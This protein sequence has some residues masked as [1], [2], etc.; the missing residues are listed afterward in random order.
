ML[1]RAFKCCKLRISPTHRGLSSIYF[2]PECRRPWAR[3][4]WTN[5]WNWLPFTN[6]ALIMSWTK[7]CF[8]NHGEPLVEIHWCF[9]GGLWRYFYHLKPSSWQ[10][11]GEVY[12]S[13]H[14][15]WG[16]RNRAF[17]KADLTCGWALFHM[18]LIRD[19]RE[20][21]Y[22]TVTPFLLGCEIEQRRLCGDLCSA[23]YVRWP[24]W[25][26]LPAWCSSWLTR[27]R[28][29]AYYSG[30]PWGSEWRMRC[31]PCWGIVSVNLQ[32]F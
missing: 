12:F 1:P 23:V 25:A 11:Q 9:D 26:L 2:G 29:A 31:F 8:L 20:S 21:R 6:L 16:R 17:L 15:T 3:Q 24:A 7:K 4:N 14:A 32:I 22:S 30:R 18:F 10:A 13:Q 27:N 5:E 28:H 19:A